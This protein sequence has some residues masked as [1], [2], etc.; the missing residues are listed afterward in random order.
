MY[1]QNQLQGY[2]AI[3][4][5]DRFGQLVH[6]LK[7]QLQQSDD[8]TVDLLNTISKGVDEGQVIL[9]VTNSHSISSGFGSA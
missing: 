7:Q 8:G 2:F 1:T 5:H 3:L 9:T 4:Y 6:D